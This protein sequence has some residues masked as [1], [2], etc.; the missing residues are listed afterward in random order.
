MS[1][2][3]CNALRQHLGRIGILSFLCVTLLLTGCLSAPTIERTRYYTITPKIEVEQTAST[4][5]TLGVRPLFTSRT[6]GPAM[7]Y[8]DQGNLLAYR[9]HNEWAESPAAVVTRAVV[10]GLAA[11]G[12][13]ADVGNAADMVRPDFILTGELRIYQENRTELPACAELE[14]RLEM[15]PTLAQGVLY[16]ETIRETEALLEDNSQAFATAMNIAVNR[17]ASRAATALSQLPLPEKEAET[18]R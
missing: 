11:S 15:R 18:K 13:F 17:F 2:R 5:F 12:R 1:Y 3:Y 6:Y 7:A 9:Q 14:V 4:A 16:A 10:D 8:L